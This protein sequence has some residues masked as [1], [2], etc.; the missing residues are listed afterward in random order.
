MRFS[1]RRVHDCLPQVGD[2]FL[3]DVTSNLDRQDTKLFHIIC[4]SPAGGFPVGTVITSR[5]DEVTV[6]AG[7][8]DL[9]KS[10]L[11]V[12]A[13][14]GRG[15]KGPKIAMTDDSQAEQNAL[16]ATWPEMV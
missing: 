12:R 15:E 4:P 13:F 8:F 2:M 5:Q 3:V 6:K 9:Y 10:L 1:P 7:C 14:F 16:N 11:P